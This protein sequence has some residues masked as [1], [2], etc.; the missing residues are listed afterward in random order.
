MAP[1]DSRTAMDMHRA[2]WQSL[3]FTSFNLVQSDGTPEHSEGL[4]EYPI[5]GSRQFHCRCVKRMPRSVCPQIAAPTLLSSA[6]A[7]HCPLLTRTAPP[8]GE[9]PSFPAAVSPS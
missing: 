1:S 9:A 4:V 8:V 2:A 7:K 5:L 3:T 6:A